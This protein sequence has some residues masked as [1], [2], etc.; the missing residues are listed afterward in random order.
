MKNKIINYILC[1]L[2]LT[3]CSSGIT[4]TS[5]PIEKTPTN[6]EEE[7]TT[8]T[9]DGRTNTVNKE[10]ENNDKESLTFRIVDTGQV[11]CYDEINVMIKCPNMGDDYYGQDAQ[12]EGYQPTY[13]LSED[14]KTVYDHIT[15][16][17]W[18]RSPNTTN[19]VPVYEDKKTV[20]EALG[21]PAELNDMAYGGYMD[22]RL[23]TI[24]E[25]Y[26]LILFSGKDI[27]GYSGVNTSVLTPF[28]DTNYFYFS[29]GDIDKDGRLLESQYYS[30]TTFINNPGDRGYQ[31]QFGVNFAD[32]RIKGYDVENPEG[33]FLFYVQCVRGNPDYGINDF[34]DNLDETITDQVTGLMWSQFDSGLALTWEGALAWVQEK[35][36]ESFL[37]Y[38]DWRLP[39]IKELQGIVDYSNAPEYNKEP[40]IDTDFFVVTLIINEQ[41]EDDYP[42]FWSSTTH[43]SYRNSTQFDVGNAA[44]YQ[45]FG[46]ALGYFDKTS[47][48]IDV[49][50]AGAQRSDPKSTDMSKY[51]FITVNGIEGYYFGPQGDAIR[52]YNFVRL[53][54]DAQE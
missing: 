31:K 13:S 33:E 48:W 35:N 21:V 19:T 14:G 23:P 38:S 37:G 54:R 49:H 42:Y 2:M 4:K 50:G 30:T 34:V 43:A 16:L 27:S 36:Q 52:G 46:R 17:T 45:T 40:A 9:A 15:E 44:A 47:S 51:E 3:G 32:G 11:N 25:L 1:L 6:I 18:Q 5:N 7:L 28:I 26:S 8:V 39:T 29:Y 24:K 10:T 20:E 12:H 41:G 22:W 53:V